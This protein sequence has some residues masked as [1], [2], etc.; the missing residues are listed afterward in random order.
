MKELEK[1][2]KALAN[3]RRLAILKYLKENR[4]AYVGNIADVIH[5]SLRQL[6]SILVF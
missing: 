1:M 5:L 4:E 2:L 6:Q 3:R